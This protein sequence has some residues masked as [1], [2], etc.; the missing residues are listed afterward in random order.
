MS[1]VVCKSFLRSP[2]SEFPSSPES[3]SE[4]RSRKQNSARRA[5]GGGGALKGVGGLQNN[6]S[7]LAYWNSPWP[8]GSPCL[9]TVRARAARP[10]L[11]AQRSG[12]EKTWRT[13]ASP[14]PAS[15]N[16]QRIQGARLPSDS[17][18]R[19]QGR[20]GNAVGKAQGKGQVEGQP[21]VHTDEPEQTALFMES[22]SEAGHRGR[23]ACSV[24][25]GVQTAVS[26]LRVY[27][28]GEGPRRGGRARAFPS[29]V[30]SPSPPRNLRH[31]L[32]SSP[33]NRTYRRCAREISRAQPPAEVAGCRSSP[34]SRPTQ[35]SVFTNLASIR[36]G[37]VLPR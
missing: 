17:E 9:L 23:T 5:R 29:F 3:R 24:T 20:P 7:R 35:R 4:V 15:Q 14:T 30:Y 8:P 12:S 26:I 33:A 19:P 2:L 10:G 1:V 36:V 31:R 37:A 21:A 11:A 27:S 32:H 6:G 16:S 25:L 34:G 18:A 28:V 22:D 13:T